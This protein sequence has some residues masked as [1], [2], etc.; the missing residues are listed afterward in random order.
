MPPQSKAASKS[1]ETARAL[2]V[3][4]LALIGVGKLGEGLLSGMLGSQ[5]LPV[6]HVAV[7]VAH[8]NTA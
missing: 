4:K 6:S 3:R 1:P 5:L 7:T 2:R 8:R